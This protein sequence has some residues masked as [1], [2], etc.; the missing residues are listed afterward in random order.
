[1]VTDDHLPRES[2]LEALVTA[3]HY[4][5]PQRGSNHWHHHHAMAYTLEPHNRAF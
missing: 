3:Y 5:H 2:C 1:M 4:H